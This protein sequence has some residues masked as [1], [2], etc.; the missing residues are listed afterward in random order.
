MR[1]HMLSPLSVCLFL[2]GLT[3]HQNFTEKMKTGEDTVIKNVSFPASADTGLRTKL[4]KAE[5]LQS[6]HSYIYHMLSRL[7]LTLESALKNFQSKSR[8][9][10]FFPGN[11][12]RKWR[13]DGDD[14]KW[15]MEY[16]HNHCNVCMCSSV[17]WDQ[18]YLTPYK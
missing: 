4:S 17:A 18:V 2:V 13:K 12:Q 5:F 11:K 16:Q 1:V 9:I 8:L 14:I 10:S 6:I 7:L 3:F 15:S